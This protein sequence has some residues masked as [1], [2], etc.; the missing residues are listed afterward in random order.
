VRLAFIVAL[1]LSAAPAPAQKWTGA[2]FCIC[3]S[4]KRGNVQLPQTCESFCGAGDSGGGFRAPDHDIYEQR[5]RDAEAVER[6]RRLREDIERK[7]R[8]E[9]QRRFEADK[10]EALG[11]LKGVSKGSVE[12]KGVSGTNA[13]G[14]K[15]VDVDKTGL[16]GLSPGRARSSAPQGV[17]AQL[18]CSAAI[19]SDLAGK[20][21]SA[22]APADIQELRERV[23]VVRNG[24]ASEEGCEPGEAPRPYKPWTPEQKRLY[25]AALKKIEDLA[26]R[27][28]S[29]ED[30]LPAVQAKVA[31]L[32][33]RAEKPAPAPA[34]A[35]SAPPPT[36]ETKPAPAAPPEKLDAGADALLAD[37]LRLEAELTKAVTESKAKLEEVDA[38]AKGF[39]ED[40]A[41]PKALADAL[42]VK[43]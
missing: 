15:G 27:K 13:F 28:V 16:K 3:P 8:E 18:A 29:A 35:P 24:G 31:E 21:K 12:L 26:R 43:P 40:P 25:I 39:A 42:G 7:A 41:D 33:K 23:G 19:G 4:G 20:A 32:R 6:A 11:Q 14:L 9:K 38:A 22:D 30:K 36:P 10:R 2:A 37:A 34:P 17:W 1:G 5:Q